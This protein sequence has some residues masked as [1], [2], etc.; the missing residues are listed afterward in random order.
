MSV[1]LSLHVGQKGR[2][3]FTFGIAISFS[4]ADEFQAPV[5]C[6]LGRSRCPWLRIIAFGSGTNRRNLRK[7]LKTMVAAERPELSTA[8]PGEQ[9]EAD[10]GLEEPTKRACYTIG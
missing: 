3:R 6:E 8:E 1:K 7:R 4:L 10:T 9:E 2:K 5:R